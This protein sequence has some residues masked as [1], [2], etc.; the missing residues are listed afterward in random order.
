MSGPC[1]GK[2][3][4]SQEWEL[5]IMATEAAAVASEPA[6]VEIPQWE[7]KTDFCSLSWARTR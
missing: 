6:Q 1:C 7:T 2:R 4:A 3:W 5:V